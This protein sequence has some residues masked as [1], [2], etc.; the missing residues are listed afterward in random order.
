MPSR[1]GASSCYT[2]RSGQSSR[3]ILATAFGSLFS[4]LLDFVTALYQAVIT[5]VPY[6]REL[7]LI[8]TIEAHD[9][10]V[11]NVEGYVDRAIQ[12]NFLGSLEVIYSATIAAFSVTTVITL[13]VISLM[14]L[15]T[16][17]VSCATRGR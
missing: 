1:Y 7:E 12:A 3:L 2:V 13:F 4:E 14:M 5:Y 15:R 11:D 9:K 10:K 17:Q 16:V 6:F 8:Y